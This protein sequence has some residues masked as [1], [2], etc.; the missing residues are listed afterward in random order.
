MTPRGA[1]NR[2]DIQPVVWH[3]PAF[4]ARA[5]RAAG[6][7]PLPPVRLYPIVGVGPE[8]VALDAE[9]RI[10]TC[11][12]D[13]R[14]LRLSPGGGDAE[15]VASTGGRPLGVE[16]DRDGTY[17]VCDAYRGLL[18]VDPVH[19]DVTE[20]VAAAVGVAGKPLGICDN[21]SIAA[22]GTIWFS[23]SSSR[24]TLEHWKADLLEHSG[25]GRLIRLDPD[26]HTEV[27]VDG[28]HFAN[29]VA[30]AA[31][32]SF[33]VVIETGAYRLT[34]L[35]LTGSRAGTV[36]RLVDNLPAFADNVSLGS[37]GLFWIA[38]ASPRKALVDWLAPKH[39][40]LRKTVWALPEA[41]Q[42]GP[43]DTAWVQ[44]VT[45]TGELV[46]DLQA[47]VDGF[48]MVT[49]VREHHGVV[50]LGSLHGQAIAA[51]DVPPV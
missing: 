32:E 49:G 9:G 44:A 24:F 8:D 37:D 31:D 47:R 46:H 51:F 40:V 23:D 33:V 5:R 36:D 15:V 20:L 29:G 16:V 50:W 34:R 41:L 10:V 12:E 26:G 28:L 13:G 27:A 38:M 4:P 30:L 3:P 22:D 21:A 1:A 17:V 19:G 6:D 39:P 42:P 7:T 18:R 35:W 43:A 25:T 45:A 2:P 11:V 14:V 48:S